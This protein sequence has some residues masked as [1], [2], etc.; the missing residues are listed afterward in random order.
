MRA[1]TGSAPE[2]PE[3]G[4]VAG[5]ISIAITTPRVSDTEVAAIT[6]ALLAA[7]PGAP[8]DGQPAGPPAW[9]QA[10]LLESATDR[11]VRTPAELRHPA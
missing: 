1:V 6:V 5:G 3:D 11:R 7:T 8:A 10:G 2:V 4:A 9:R